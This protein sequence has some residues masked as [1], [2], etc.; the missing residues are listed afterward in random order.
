[1]SKGKFGIADIVAVDP[2]SPSANWTMG[3]T[4]D[5]CPP[6]A[7]VHTPVSLHLDVLFLI[8]FI[9]VLLPQPFLGTKRRNDGFTVTIIAGLILEII[10]F[11]GRV[12]LTTNS[13]LYAPFLLS[14]VCHALG[15]VFVNGAIGLFFGRMAAACDDPPERRARV[16]NAIVLFAYAG[17]LVSL[18][19]GAV[20][21]VYITL[22]ED[23]SLVSSSIPP[24]GCT[25]ETLPRADT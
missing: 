14:L 18:V 16:R 24:S 15:P 1:M 7:L 17:N 23:E 12:Q 22:A 8:F 25:I 4:F 2:T 13:S 6:L 10:G 9:L 21:C 3:C 5:V 11:G 19:V 20:G